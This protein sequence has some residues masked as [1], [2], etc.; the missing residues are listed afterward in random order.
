[1]KFVKHI[2]HVFRGYYSEIGSESLS[3]ETGLWPFLDNEYIDQ[4]KAEMRQQYIW[5]VA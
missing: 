4:D 2:F 3:F 5:R 1:M